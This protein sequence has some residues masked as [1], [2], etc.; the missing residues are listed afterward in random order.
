MEA[1]AW[2][3]DYAGVIAAAEPALLMSG[4]SPMALAPLGVAHGRLG[5]R[6]VAEAVYAELLARET[7]EYVQPFWIAAAAAAAGRM[8]EAMSFANRAVDER[9]SFAMTARQIPEWEPLRAH[10]G[11]GD[12]LRRL[13]LPGLT[14]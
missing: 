4:R 3:R 7:T 1:Y 14:V 8:E 13:G 9:D 6:K 5:N 10:P 12:L 11:F 2:A